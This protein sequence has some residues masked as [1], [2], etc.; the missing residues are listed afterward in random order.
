MAD[1]SESRPTDL[2]AGIPEKEVVQA[3]PTTL[4]MRLA[5]FVAEWEWLW[6]LLILPAV[7]FPNPTR[8]LVLLLLPLLWLARRVATGRFV[9]ASPLNGSVLLLLFM[10]LVSLYANSD[11]A[12]SFSK[13][14]GLAYGVSVFYAVVVMAGRN[15]RSFFAALLLFQG[16]GI[17]LSLLGLITLRW[18]SNK[19]PF[20]KPLLPLI[21]RQFIS[22]PGAPEGVSPNQLA[23]MLLWLL[24]VALALA[25]LVLF[26][27]GEWGKWV[28]WKR[29]ALVFLI[30]AGAAILG[31]TFVLAQSRSGLLGIALAVPF[32]LLIPLWRYRI[33]IFAVVVLISVA[34]ILLLSHETGEQVA[35][36]VLSHAARLFISNVADTIDHLEAR[37]VI[38]SRAMGA[39]HDFPWTGV[40][41]G[42]F[43][44]V[45]PQ[46]Y[47][48]FSIQFEQDVGH[49]HNHLVQ[50][51]LD[52]GIPGLIAYL[53]LWLGVSVML[54]QI[55][56]AGPLIWQRILTLAFAG[57]L[58]SYF[59]YGLTD[60]VGLGAKPG[61]LFWFLLGLIAALHRTIVPTILE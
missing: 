29:L 26:R 24:P 21:P 32:V 23:G 4:I 57:A 12:F 16:L 54:R 60:T 10:L 6:L 49:A 9:P 34:G 41:T 1:L 40:G 53:G 58:L 61:F 46:L 42:M 22:L 45:A 44:Q 35:D 11:L 5:R 55:W 15:G 28:W 37:V 50:T 8:A 13:I 7:L 18:S 25:L 31:G 2:R 56:R 59:I 27:N 51:T 20:L 33:S 14:A 36:S 47:P 38:W 43:R 3:A 19:L 30:W 39:I 17:S 48:F 52:L